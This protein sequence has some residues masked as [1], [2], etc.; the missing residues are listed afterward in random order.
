MITPEQR[1]ARAMEVRYY[2]S[3]NVDK[4]SKREYTVLDLRFGLT[5]GTTHTLETIGKVYGLTRE[6]I[7][8]IEEKAL[9]KI[10]ILSW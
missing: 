10:G 5:D 3:L 9:A 4:L 1:E 2:L 7:R 6:R 8:Q